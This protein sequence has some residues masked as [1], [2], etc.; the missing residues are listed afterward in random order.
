[1]NIYV[2][3]LGSKVTDEDLKKLFSE[4]GQVSSAKVI[5]DKFTGVSRGFAFVEGDATINDIVLSRRDG[6]GITETDM[7]TIKADSQAEILLMEVPM[8]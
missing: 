4:F 1:M 2:S 6:L 8:S 7:L 3:S 5:N